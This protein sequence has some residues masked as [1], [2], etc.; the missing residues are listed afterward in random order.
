MNLLSVTQESEVESME[1]K[2]KISGKRS[3]HF[4]Q[5]ISGLW[6]LYTELTLKSTDN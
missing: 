6:A 1:V 2:R 4:P 5:G 3:G